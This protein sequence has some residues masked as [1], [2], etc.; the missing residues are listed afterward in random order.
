MLSHGVRMFV[1]RPSD[2]SKSK[3]KL[4]VTKT[5]NPDCETIISFQQLIEAVLYNDVILFDKYLTLDPSL[6]DQNKNGYTIA[7]IIAANSFNYQMIVCLEKHLKKNNKFDLLFV[8]DPDCNIPLHFAMMFNS[9]QMILALFAI[10]DARRRYDALTWINRQLVNS[11]ITAESRS[12]AIP[13]LFRSYA[14]SN[15]ITPTPEPLDEKK[16]E[17]HFPAAKETPELAALLRYGYQIANDVSAMNT[18]ASTDP[19]FNADQKSMKKR[20]DLIEQMRHEYA[21]EAAIINHKYL[22][23]NTRLAKL[24]QLNHRLV[25]KYSKTANCMELARLCLE[26]AIEIAPNVQSEL[27]FIKNDDHWFCVIGR[28]PRSDIRNYKSWGNAVIIDVFAKVKNVYPA[29]AIPSRLKYY[30]YD[31]IFQTNIVGPINHKVHYFARDLFFYPAPKVTD[32]K[33]PHKDIY[34]SVVSA[35]S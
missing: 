21:K 26:R 33:L 31:T 16:I 24:L 4:P 20:C 10:I 9:E 8:E 30:Y 6:L 22:A 25:I 5:I 29:T 13:K 12:D 11:L 19:R 34:S 35:F 27:V 23:I 2:E 14:F 3:P 32:N 18:E 7:H 28:D 17:I 1:A 15:P